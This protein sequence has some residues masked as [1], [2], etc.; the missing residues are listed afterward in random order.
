MSTVIE[1]PDALAERLRAAADAEGLDLNNYAVAKL[2]RSLE[3]VHV[4]DTDDEADDD[5]IA[6]LRQGIADRNAG[7]LRTLEQVDATV[8]AA[9][10]ARR[11]RA[12]MKNT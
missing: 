11:V 8:Y 2:E 9:L 7:N 3:E 1:L 6:A 10:A 4:Q 12:V 5:L